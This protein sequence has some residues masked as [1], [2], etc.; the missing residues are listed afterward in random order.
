MSYFTASDLERNYAR[1]MNFSEIWYCDIRNQVTHIIDYEGKMH[2][3]ERYEPLIEGEEVPVVP[4]PEK[5]HLK[6]N[7]QQLL[8]LM[9]YLKK[10]SSTEQLHTHRIFL[11]D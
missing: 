3:T 10:L 7:K 8:L 5:I 4:I 9:L 1:V 2:V 6:Y 11:L